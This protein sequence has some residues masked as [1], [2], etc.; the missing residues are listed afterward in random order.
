MLSNDI[1]YKFSLINNNKETKNNQEGQGEAEIL[2]GHAPGAGGRS[3]AKSREIQG[4]GLRRLQ[5]TKPHTEG[6]LTKN[7]HA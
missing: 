6:R 1:I 5:N 2:T 3:Y 4:G 7:R